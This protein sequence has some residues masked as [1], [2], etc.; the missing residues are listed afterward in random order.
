MLTFFG[1][2]HK[3]INKHKKHMEFFCSILVILADDETK[4]KGKVA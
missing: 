1:V 4:V 3:T 2:W